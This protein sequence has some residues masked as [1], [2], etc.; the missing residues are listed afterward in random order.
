[1]LLLLLIAIYIIIILLEVPDL[2]RQGWHR[3]LIV[4]FVI[5][6][7]GIF[8]SLAQFYNWPLYNPLERI[9]MT[10]GHYFATP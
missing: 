6:I 5:F 8:L 3:E 4:F 10:A 9:I 7:A 1:M 2:M